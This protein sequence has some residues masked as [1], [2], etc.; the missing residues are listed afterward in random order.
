MSET[1][2]SNPADSGVLEGQGGQ[3]VEKI[4][5]Q[6]LPAQEAEKDLISCPESASQGPLFYLPH[7]NSGTPDEQR[8]SCMGGPLWKEA[9]AI[10]WFPP[11]WG[12]NPVL[13]LFRK[14]E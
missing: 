11:R 4:Q 1:P 6:V 10:T 12:E 13:Q 9:K 8:A 5:K 2:F 14:S 3:G 7:L